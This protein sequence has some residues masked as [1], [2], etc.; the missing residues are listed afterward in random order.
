MRTN[1]VSALHVLEARV[2][3]HVVVVGDPAPQVK[4]AARNEASA[5]VAGYNSDERSMPRASRKNVLL[6]KPVF[7]V[8]APRSGS[9][10][11]FDTLACSAGFNT[12]GVRRIG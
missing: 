2:L 5:Q 7:I 4:A 6:D 10:L 8:A 9:T 12:L 3:K 1:G 11:L